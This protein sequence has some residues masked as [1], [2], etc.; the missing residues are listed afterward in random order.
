MNLLKSK[1]MTVR[2]VK[3]K[4]FLIIFIIGL[5][6]TSH[7]QNKEKPNILMLCIDDMN[8]WVGFLGGHP[9]AKT[10]NMDKLANRGVNFTKAYCTAPGCSPSR[11]A[12]LFGI[13]PHN[14]GLYPFYDINEIESEV[15]EPYT[16]LPLLF[17][18]NG[19]KTV[20]LGKVF[21]NPDNRYKQ[22]EIW[23]EYKMYANSKLN[24][25]K[26][27]G[28][29]PEPY[30]KRLVSCPANNPAT[31]FK[32]RKSADH[33]IRFLEKKHNKPFFLAVGFILPHT[34]FIT[35]EENYDRF[36]L[37]I[38]EP[39]IRAD[40]LVDIPLTGRS[41]AQIYVELPL[42][43]D[44][45]WE[46][47]RRG[48]LASISFTDDN[49]G[50][51]LDAL[52]KSIYADNTIVVL[53]SDHGF[54][55]GEKRTFS[56]F[57]LW[58]EATRTP[59]IILDPRKKEGHGEV[60]EQTVG[61]IN[62][63]KTISDLANIETPDYV[64]GMSL[65]PWL[66][67]PNKQLDRPAMTTWGRGNYSLRTKKWRY[68]RY[69]DGSEELYDVIKDSNEWTNLANKAEY[70]E[71]MQQLADKW[72]PK[73]EAPQVKSGRKLYNVV[74]A[75]SPTRALKIFKNKSNEFKLLNLKPALD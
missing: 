53:W 23:D 34:P 61:L 29:Y 75:D 57:S 31:D 50:L 54:H 30:N 28:Y 26:D 48:Y 37:P 42:R 14:S 55:L 19:Y 5:Y 70:K 27:K 74:D 25:L 22:D 12:L 4:F 18:Q 32:D 3:I 6:T 45:A 43:R 62:V 20:G 67:S 13:E 38:F 17:R 51:V 33:A 63:Y 60:C 15:L 41:N 11:N 40:D 44:N 47:V 71:L 8:D 7:A 16:A 52:E 1:I 2:A 65:A 59:F 72:L 10:P 39:A 68:T 36:N 49:V 58:E 46:K 73:N 9:Q 56:K 35:P 66:V 21:H 69:F 24:L 64:D